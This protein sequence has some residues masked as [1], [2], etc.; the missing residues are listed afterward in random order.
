[1]QWDEMTNKQK[2][3][4]QEKHG[5][6]DTFG[7]SVIELAENDTEMLKAGEQISYQDIKWMREPLE[8]LEHKYLWYRLLTVLS[9]RV[10]S[11]I[12][13]EFLDAIREIEY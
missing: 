8:E 11:P 7:P 12:D 10:E 6:D 1:M 5:L 3:E 9:D 2:N 13:P 4:F